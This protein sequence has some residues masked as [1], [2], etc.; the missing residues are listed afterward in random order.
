VTNFKLSFKI[1]YQ[2]GTNKLEY[3]CSPC[4]ELKMV[5]RFYFLLVLP[6]LRFH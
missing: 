2:L 3:Q 1:D 4:P 6:S 5:N